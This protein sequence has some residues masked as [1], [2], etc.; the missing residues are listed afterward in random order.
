MRVCQKSQM[1]WM[2]KERNVSYFV[3]G[4]PRHML[5]K[6]KTK[7]CLT[8]LPKPEM[9]KQIILGRWITVMCDL[10]IQC[11]SSQ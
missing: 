4:F 2:N 5:V 10:E 6:G 8:A 7:M 9:Q 3:Y 11:R 1:T